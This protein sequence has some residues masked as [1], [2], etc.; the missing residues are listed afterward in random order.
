MAKSLSAE[1]VLD[2]FATLVAEK[3]AEKL[4]LGSDEEVEDEEIEDD[5]AVEDE[6]YEDDDESEDEES[7]EEGDDEDEEPWTEESLGE[8]SRD[9]LKDLAE[10][11]EI[12]FSPKT[13]DNTLIAA[14][15]EAQDAE[16]GEP[17]DEDEPEEE[18]E[19][20]DDDDEFWTEAELKAKAI[21]ELKS[22]AKD[23]GITSKGMGKSE[24]IEAILSE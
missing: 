19:S 6:D 22:I 23:Y 10:Q 9:E 4:D 13:R 14:I 20:G 3:V 2:Y 15:L 16:E 18:E 12:E 1:D 17:E 21:G 5:E 11:Y 24:L 8:L 7:E